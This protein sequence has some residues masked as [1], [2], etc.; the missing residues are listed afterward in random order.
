MLSDIVYRKGTVSTRSLWSALALQKA[1]TDADV[2][3]AG[4]VSNYS[5]R[6]V[7]PNLWYPYP[8]G[9][10]ANR[11]GVRENNIGNDG[12]HQKKKELR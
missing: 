1:P 4:H 9:Y 2:M 7:F 11:L 5:S 6:A 12:K 8:W 10:A 3:C